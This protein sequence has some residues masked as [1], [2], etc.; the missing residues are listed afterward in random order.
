MQRRRRSTRSMRPSPVSSGGPGRRPWSNM[1]RGVQVAGDGLLSSSPPPDPS[2]SSFL[3]DDSVRL[4]LPA[5]DRLTGSKLRN[6]AEEII[7]HMRSSKSSDR[8][9]GA[10]LCSSLVS[11]N[12]KRL[13]DAMDEEAGLLSMQ[14]DSHVRDP[15]S[16]SDLSHLFT[17]VLTA[18][19]PLLLDQDPDVRFSAGETLRYTSRPFTFLLL[20]FT[21]GSPLCSALSPII[22]V[23]LLGLYHISFYR[24]CDPPT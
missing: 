1:V 19:T 14:M 10:V 2:S 16:H 23:L 18:L 24:S 21:R 22:P 20:L 6:W 12:R 8:Q 4:T 3:P 7:A 5:D 11:C 17:E 9:Y 15:L 13:A